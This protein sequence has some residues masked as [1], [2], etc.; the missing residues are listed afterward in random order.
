MFTESQFLF[1][2]SRQP[3]LSSYFGEEDVIQEEDEGGHQSEA[4]S[5]QDS[6]SSFTRPNL[7]PEEEGMW[8]QCPDFCY[9]W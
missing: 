5:L 7:G 4:H 1:D 9:T 8:S 6:S 2:R 3:N